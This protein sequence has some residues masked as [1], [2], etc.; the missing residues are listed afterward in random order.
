MSTEKSTSNSTRPGARSQFASQLTEGRER[1]L[2]HAIEHGF[3]IGRRTPEDFLRHFPPRAIM[4]GLRDQPRLRSNILVVA[5][6]VRAKVATKKS[7]ASAGDDL[8]IALDEGETDPAAIVSLFEPDDRV[9]YLDHER[10]WAYVIEGDFW[11][12]GAAD[13]SALEQA[14]RHV[15]FMLDRGLADA[16]ITERDIVEGITVHTLAELLPRPELERV[17][18][19]TLGN[20]R[21]GAAFTERD[22]LAQVSATTLV[23]DIPLPVVWDRVIAPRIAVAH[24]FVKVAAP[25]PRAVAAAV[26]RAPVTGTM[27]AIPP[28]AATTERAPVTGTMAAI[29]A[30]A[31]PANAAPATPS[32]ATP[33][34]EETAP[35][36]AES[37]ADGADA[38][39][40]VPRLLGTMPA[41]ATPFRVV[42]PNVEVQSSARKTRRSKPPS[43]APAAPITALADAAT[44]PEMAHILRGADEVDVEIDEDDDS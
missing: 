37:P 25:V 14:S 42:R 39:R 17:L 35:A 4:E 31:T 30:A 27:A 19:A 29:P 7:A 41:S 21:Q 12:V 36:R 18:T 38:K 2:A 40:V 32:T 43:M 15:A 22:F 20:A 26:E 11:K 6:G 16:L 5:T 24:A 10:L 1:F 9:R 28:A 34:A 23:K 13:P 44:S 8:Q 33:A 3:E